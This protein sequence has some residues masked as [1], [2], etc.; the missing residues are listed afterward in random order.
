M[1]KISAV[2]SEENFSWPRIPPDLDKGT[3]GNY[4]PLLEALCRHTGLPPTHL[5]Q[6]IPQVMDYANVQG[7]PFNYPGL[8]NAQVNQWTA[9]NRLALRVTE[10]CDFYYAQLGW[11]K[12]NVA[13]LLR[14]AGL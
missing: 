6:E 12:S 9:H 7:Q 5:P 11:P 2:M 10:V 14:N 4:M 1:R 13:Q 8:S 3:K